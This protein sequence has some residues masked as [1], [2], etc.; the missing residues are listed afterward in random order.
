MKIK[1]WARIGTAI[2]IEVEKPT[3]Q[4]IGDA[5]KKAINK[6]NTDNENFYP[7]G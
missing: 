5:L 3:R 7:I 2:I 1:I 6:N 4:Q